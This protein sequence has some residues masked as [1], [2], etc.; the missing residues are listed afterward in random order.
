MPRS[1]CITPLI[2][3]W[4]SSY[5][6]CS[7]TFWDINCVRPGSRTWR[8]FLTDD[9]ASFGWTHLVTDNF[10]FDHVALFVVVA[11]AWRII[12]SVVRRFAC[13]HGWLGFPQLVSVISA[14]PRSIGE[15]FT[16]DIS[17]FSRTHSKT[18]NFIFDNCKFFFIVAWAWGI[19]SS[20]ISRLT[21]NHGRLSLPQL[22]SVI[23]AWS[24]SLRKLLAHNISPLRWTHPITWW[25]ISDCFLVIT[26]L[27]RSR[28][29]IPLVISWSPCDPCCSSIL[30]GWCLVC[31]WS[32][33][34]LSF[35]A[36]HVTLL[37]VA[38]LVR[39][40]LIFYCAVV[41]IKT[42]WSWYV[43]ADFVHGFASYLGWSFTFLR[44]NFVHSWSWS[45]SNFRAHNIWSF[46]WAH[47]VWN[48][49]VFD[50]WVFFTI[51]SWSWWII[52]LVVSWSTCNC[53]RELWSQRW[54]FVL[55]RSWL[56]LLLRTNDVTSF[57]W[58]HLERDYSI[59]GASK[60]FI[61]MAW[62][63][64]IISVSISSFA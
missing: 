24:R 2:I 26:I 29:I 20:I 58:T 46:T 52:S 4:F 53:C 56:W 55:S 19:I 28:R 34:R 54:R 61:V 18:N 45:W 23:S 6:S 49:S 40:D 27:P 62:P 48:H 9:I 30:C 35:L 11:W 50:C 42:S 32:R 3:L 22:V 43:V 15:F 21:S 12:S 36:H 38:H 5:Q 44:L 47:L 13:D 64:W 57:W 25:L 31:S 17:S 1:W 7:F 16:Y 33:L 51:S 8:C 14:W 63:W 41:G 39:H 60:L 10:V 59:F 37:C